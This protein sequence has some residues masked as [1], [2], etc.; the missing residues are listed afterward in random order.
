[1]RRDEPDAALRQ[2]FRDI[3]N[4]FRGKLAARVPDTQLEDVLWRQ[5]LALEG[6]DVGE[7]NRVCSTMMIDAGMLMVRIGDRISA[8]ERERERTHR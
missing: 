1:M 7:L 3:A 5:V 4:F 2:A 6:V 8:R